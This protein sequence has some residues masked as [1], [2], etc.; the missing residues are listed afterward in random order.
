M[1]FGA[2][3]LGVGCSPSRPA[4]DG[5]TR[6]M[7][8]LTRQVTRH[9]RCATWWS[10]SDSARSRMAWFAA[11]VSKESRR[12]AGRGGRARLRPGESQT[13]SHG[14]P[15][16]RR[17]RHLATR[18]DTHRSPT[19]QRAQAARPQGAPLGQRDRPYRAP[20]IRRPRRLT[21]GLAVQ[22]GRGLRRYHSSYSPG[23]VVGRVF[24]RRARLCSSRSGRTVTLG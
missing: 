20:R 5:H 3:M 1:G 17:H 23:P 6:F 14:P 18:S 13:R 16:P 12:R 21:A 2:S 10:G 24:C 22:V 19:G 7:W 4:V 9:I 8:S 15:R 11:S